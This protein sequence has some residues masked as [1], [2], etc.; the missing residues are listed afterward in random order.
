MIMVRVDKVQSLRIP[1]Y[2]LLIM[3]NRNSAVYNIPDPV[4]RCYYAFN[5]I[6]AFYRFH[7]RFPAQF[8]IRIRIL[9]LP[10]IPLGTQIRY[11]GR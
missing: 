9:K 3:C 10:E 5:C 2:F 1:G 4:I 11:Y 8:F 6:T 7:D